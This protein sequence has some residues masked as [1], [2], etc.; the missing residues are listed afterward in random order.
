MKIF[1]IFVVLLN[2]LYL[3]GQCIAFVEYCENFFS[4]LIYS[5]VII[6]IV[7]VPTISNAP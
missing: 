6:V 2:K 4:I 1:R 7:I 5:S 3:S